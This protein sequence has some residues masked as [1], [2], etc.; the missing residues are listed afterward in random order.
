MENFLVLLLNL[1]Q[2]F[3]LENSQPNFL[4]ISSF[5]LTH[6]QIVLT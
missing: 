1:L 3:E 6:M 5:K 4:F 2:W